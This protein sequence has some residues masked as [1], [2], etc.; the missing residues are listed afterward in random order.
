MDL[1]IK[2]RHGAGI[3]KAKVEVRA[4]RC[5]LS[6]LNAIPAAS[7]DRWRRCLDVPTVYGSGSGRGGSRGQG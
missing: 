5:M 2:V 6:Y 7:P 3:H 1:D 4:C